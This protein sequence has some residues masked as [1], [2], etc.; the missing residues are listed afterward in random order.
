MQGSVIFE[1]NITQTQRNV[2]IILYGTILSAAFLFSQKDI[3]QKTDQVE[4][5]LVH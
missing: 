5:Y 2:S 3:R 1:R 4:A